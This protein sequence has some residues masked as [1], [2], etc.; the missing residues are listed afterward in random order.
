MTEYHKSQY[1][2]WKMSKIFLKYRQNKVFKKGQLSTN[3][4]EI[5]TNSKKLRETFKCSRN[6]L[7]RI[8]FLIWRNKFFDGKCTWK[9]PQEVLPK[10]TSHKGKRS[11]LE[12]QGNV[13]VQKIVMQRNFGRNSVFKHV[14]AETEI[15]ECFGRN[16]LNFCAFILPLLSGDRAAFG[17]KLRSCKL[18]REPKQLP[19]IL[20]KWLK[21][22]EKYP[23]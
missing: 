13:L 21:I 5:A 14:S 1:S 18:F 2:I 10:C 17:E 16:Y 7:K 9:E 4:S 19:H 22:V 6:F 8:I 23:K 20:W 3:W 12:L 15:R 11:R